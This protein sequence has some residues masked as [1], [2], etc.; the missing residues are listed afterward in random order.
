MTTRQLL[1]CVSVLSC[2]VALA[3][4]N[5]GCAFHGNSG[6]PKESLTG[7]SAPVGRIDFAEFIG[8]HS[9]LDRHEIEFSGQRFKRYH[10]TT[11]DVMTRTPDHIVPDMREW[12]AALKVISHD[13]FAY[14]IRSAHSSA[15]SRVQVKVRLDDG[16]WSNA[17]DVTNPNP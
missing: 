11:S 4:L 10:V 5:T 9:R 7:E 3:A 15:H 1:P 6:S 8:S 16:N 13:A 17:F 2:S 12:K 14:H